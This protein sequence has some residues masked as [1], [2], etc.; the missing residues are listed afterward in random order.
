LYCTGTKTSLSMNLMWLP[1][2]PSGQSSWLQNERSGF[3]SQH[4]QIFW[5]VV[6]LEQGALGLVSTIEELLGRKSS[7]CGLENRKYMLTTWHPL[8][9]KVATNFADKL[10][11]LGRYSSLVD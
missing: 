1:L 9:A 10:R 6:G 7:G 8:S 11:S 2:W 5:E 3:D 4:Y